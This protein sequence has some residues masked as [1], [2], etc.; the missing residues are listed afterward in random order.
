MNEE[1]HKF[2]L[3]V[4]HIVHSLNI[5]LSSYEGSDAFRV[6]EKSCVAERGEALQR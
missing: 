3:F 4:T 5:R 6:P 1:V 2:M